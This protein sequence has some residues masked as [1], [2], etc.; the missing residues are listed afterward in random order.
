VNSSHIEAVRRFNRF[1]TRQIGLLDEKLYR[2]A[3]SLT[4]TRVL[5]ELAHTPNITASDLTRA[6]GLD[7]GYTSRILK[8]FEERGLIRRSS[9]EEDARRSHLELTAKGRK[10]FQPVNDA[11]EEKVRV[12][13]GALAET[14]R[15]KLVRAMEAIAQVLEPPEAPKVPYLLRNHQPGDMGWVVHRHGVLYAREYGWNEEFEALV[16][17]IVAKFIRNA[18]ARNER[19]W[20]AERED[21]KFGDPTIV[22]S[23]FVMKDSDEVARLR[24]LLVEPSARGLGIGARLVKECID[25][26]TS[27][28]YRKLVLWTNDCLASARK[29]YEAQGFKLVK[30]TPHHSFGA[31]LIGQDWERELSK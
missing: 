31:D 20:I 4:E 28:G 5:Y 10:S 8:K 19:C 3:F 30:E 13:L 14:D 17:D 1:Y 9:S 6:L 21:A 11:S 27:H 25:F 18:D 22:G 2:S 26:A 23:V 24:L 16:A 12:I 29:I 7:A 15:H